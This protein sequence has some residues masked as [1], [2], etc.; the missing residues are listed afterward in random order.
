[1]VKTLNTCSDLNI[2]YQKTLLGCKNN[3][4]ASITVGQGQVMMRVSIART[5]DFVKLPLPGTSS[6]SEW[7]IILSR[8]DEVIETVKLKDLPRNKTV[9]VENILAADEE[10]Y[11]AYLSLIKTSD[12]SL[13]PVPE[14]IFEGLFGERQPIAIIFEVC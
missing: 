14:R 6:E 4:K 5:N 2:K 10:H 12:G 9:G 8:N 7:A 1:M 13:E 3:F 11:E